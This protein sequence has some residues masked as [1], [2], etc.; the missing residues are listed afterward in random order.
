[1]CGITGMFGHQ[2]RQMAEGYVRTMNACIAHRGPDAEGIWSDHNCTLGHRRLSIIDTSEAGNQPFFSADKR[3]SVVFNGEIYNYIELKKEL[4][5]GYT[6]RTASDTEVIIAAY[7]KWGKSFVHHFIGMFAIA[8]KDAETDELLVIRDRLGIKPVYWASTAS[9]YLFSSEIRA[10]LAT[11]LVKKKISSASLA[12]YLRYQTVH[13]PDTI[14]ENIHMLN[15]GHM[16][17]FKNNQCRFEKFWDAAENINQSAANHSKE[18][19][20]K[21]ILDLLTSSVEVRMRADVPFGAFLS[22]GIDS[23]VIVGLMSRISAHPVKT[24]SVTFHEKIFDESPYSDVIARKFNTEH[25]PI[26]LS[27][28]HFLDLMPEALRAMD[29]PS[30]DGPNTYVVSKVT[31]HAGVKMAL[32]GLGGD[33][34]F[35]GYDVF[36]RM[37]DLESKAWLNFIPSPFR[38][39]AG[40]ALKRAR[41]SVSSEK[42]AA[43]IGSSKIDF[44][45]FYPIVR[46]VLLDD[47]VYKLMKSK[48]DQPNHVFQL[49]CQIQETKAETL[50]KVSLAEIQTYM[51]NVLL[52]DTDQMSMAHALEVRVPFLDHRLVEYVLGVGDDIKY[53][54]TPKELLTSAVGDL[55]PHEVVHRPKM[56]FTF[57]WAVWMRNELKS[58]CYE[59]LLSLENVEAI[60]HNE[61]MHL[62]QRFLSGDP[63]ITWSRI[64]PLVVLGHWVKQHE[65]H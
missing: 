10:I 44:S 35:A 12:D 28:N 39:L 29:H 36:R 50:T 45:H 21:N 33:E 38:R 3:I 54:H 59:N 16:M 40:E 64:W 6:F 14:I 20:R 43:G 23:S 13:A 11:G 27:A 63:L 8:L 19:V 17:I 31:R 48:G 61:V 22:G 34:V 4:S 30:G 18:E 15:P 60:N 32:S 65:I 1:M 24:F 52:R 55:L 53:P 51:Q 47:Q 7:L 9:G 62:W 58:F 49:A 42:I 5:D 41:R 26:Q 46:Q 2:D 57:P 25:T 56:G 37:K